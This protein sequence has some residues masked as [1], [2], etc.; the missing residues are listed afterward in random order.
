MKLGR[1]FLVA[2]ENMA[3]H[4]LRTALTLLGLIVGITSVLL[5]TGIGRGFEQMM[6]EG[7]ANLLPTKLT[8]R[9]GFDPAG[10]STALLTMRDAD[11]LAR[12]T[13]KANLA[14]VAPFKEIYGLSVRG[15]D[16]EQ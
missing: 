7:L 11:L 16:P 10:G 13:G 2:L 12:I 4:K 14:A 5:M 3:R 8:I 1:F 9:Q 6:Q 15:F